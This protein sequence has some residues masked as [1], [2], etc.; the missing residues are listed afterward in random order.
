MTALKEWL[1][2][3]AVLQMRRAE[4]DLPEI[5]PPACERENNRPSRLL[6]CSG[7]FGDIM[8]HTRWQAYEVEKKVCEAYDDFQ[9]VV[10][11]DSGNR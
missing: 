3:G 4:T 8:Y 5:F 9:R 2:V 10:K 7:C 11:L 1:C 6:V